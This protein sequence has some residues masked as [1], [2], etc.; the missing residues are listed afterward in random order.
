MIGEQGMEKG[1]EGNGSVG[2]REKANYMIQAVAH[3]LEVLEELAKS[4]S[5]VGVTD[6]SKR[7]KLHKNNVFRLLATLELHGYVE[8]NR[9][10]EA[11]RLG[12]KVV[13]LSQSFLQQSKLAT[14]ALPI[15]RNLAEQSGETVSLAVI[16]N[17]SVQYPISLESKRPVRVASRSSQAFPAKSSAVGRLLLAQLPDSVLAE[18]LA[19]G[20]AADTA[21]KGQLAELRSGGQIIDRG[22]SELEVVTVARVVRGPQGEVVGGIEVVIP[23]FRAKVEMIAQQLEETCQMLSTS[24]GGQKGGLSQ[25]VEKSSMDRAG[26]EKIHT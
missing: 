26:S 21:L 13:Q 17:G 12:A 5:E 24:L 7:L 20:Q 8:Q 19:S 11:Y 6:L 9:D 22:A 23:Q 15:L 16:Q 10:S 2:K 25:V 14:R 3:A 18:I 1:T 4:Q